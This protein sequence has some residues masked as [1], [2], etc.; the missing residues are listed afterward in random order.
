MLE[1]N[2]GTILQLVRERR[3][4]QKMIIIADLLKNAEFSLFVQ[5]SRKYALFFYHLIILVISEAADPLHPEV[6]Q[7]L[8]RRSL[9]S[10]IV[11]GN[12]A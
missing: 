11:T 7:P 9:V 3:M 6:E 1:P 10:F 12:I 2:P 4:T 8:A 5:K